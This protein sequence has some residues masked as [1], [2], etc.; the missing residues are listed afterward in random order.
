MRNGPRVAFECF[1]DAITRSLTRDT[2]PGACAAGD[3]ATAPLWRP[4]DA[5]QRNCHQCGNAAMQQNCSSACGGTY[6][7]AC[8]LG[9]T[10][11]SVQVGDGTQGVAHS[12]TK[13]GPGHRR[14]QPNERT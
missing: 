13:R 1:P 12:D 9:K 4:N 7:S 6:T 3:N 5:P 2:A 14:S 8:R 11:P 10:R